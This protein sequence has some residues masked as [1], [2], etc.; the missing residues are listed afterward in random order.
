MTTA[1]DI[2]M[3]SRIQAAWLSARVSP[4]RSWTRQCLVWIDQGQGSVPFASRISRSAIERSA[5]CR[6]AR[7]TP[8][9]FA[10]SVRDDRTFCPFEIKPDAH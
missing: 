9:R 3:A 4:I 7:N 8:G 2:K 5:R 6:P 1:L 10:D